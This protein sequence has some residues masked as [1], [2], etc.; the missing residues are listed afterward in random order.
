MSAVGHDGAPLGNHVAFDA[1]V[2]LWQAGILGMTSKPFHRCEVRV[3][4]PYE[5]FQISHARPQE[6][7]GPK[8]LPQ[9]LQ[10]PKPLAQLQAP[11]DGVQEYMLLLDV[12]L[13]VTDQ[14]AVDLDRTAVMKWN[15]SVTAV[16]RSKDVI[17]HLALLARQGA[18]TIVA[19]VQYIATL[20][21][22]AC[23]QAPVQ[24]AMSKQLCAENG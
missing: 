3:R 12:M 23:L 7:Q 10:G 1:Y 5:S 17:Q 21:M 18:I 9:A 20:D 11:Q 24:P 6:P 8:P 14:D 13:L 4:F 22:N 16:L 15:K 19:L 2:C